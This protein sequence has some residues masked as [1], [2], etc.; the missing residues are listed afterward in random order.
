MGVFNNNLGLVG[1]FHTIYDFRHFGQ[2]TIGVVYTTTSKG[3]CGPTKGTT[4]MEQGLVFRLKL[5]R[6]LTT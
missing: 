2:E 1:C 4:T 6:L 3:M 5:V